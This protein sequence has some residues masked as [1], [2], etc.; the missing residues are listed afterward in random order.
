VTV[1]PAAL[2]DAALLGGVSGMRT[3]MAPAVLA[4]RGRL[5]DN[6]ARYALLVAA[7]GELAA[8]KH[9]AMSDRIDPPA[10]VGRMTSAAVSGRTVAGTPGAALAGGIA[11]VAAAASWRVRKEL[12]AKLP[13]PALG[14]VEDALAFSLAWFATREPHPEPEVG[15]ALA[16]V[17]AAARGVVAGAAGTVVMT[18]AQ[19]LSPTESSDAPERVGRKLIRRATGKRVPRKHRGKLNQGMHVAY[20]TSW[21]V[22]FGL[23]A[24]QLPQSPNPLA[25]G[26][27]FGLSVWAVS[28]VELPALGVAPTPWEQ[29]PRALLTDAGFHLI[30][31]LTA[32]T[33][34]KGL[35]P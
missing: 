23:L 28:L 32:A 22:P 10:L 8:D 24:A 12:G 20:G 25:A 18:L 6:P 1:T 17:E 14:A 21:G 19:L 3:F 27:T 13:D 7:T 2:R 30:Y 9:P 34:L 31:G 11:L 29:S 4:L 15:P 5:A 33:V 26:V 16:P 35:I